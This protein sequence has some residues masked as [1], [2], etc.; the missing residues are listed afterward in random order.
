MIPHTAACT[1]DWPCHS[2]C[3]HLIVS[4]IS[5][6]S[7]DSI[8]DI[9]SI[10]PWQCRAAHDYHLLHNGSS[11][12]AIVNCIWCCPANFNHAHVPWHMVD[13]KGMGNGKLSLLV[14]LV[15]P[16]LNPA[17][18]SLSQNT[19]YAKEHAIGKTHPPLNGMLHP[20]KWSCRLRLATE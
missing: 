16:R 6:Q 7:P 18:I 10:R 14:Y 9:D 15:I 5:I 11:K 20:Q 17:T 13:L 2:N 12:L 8:S 19:P 4:M 1:C 3:N